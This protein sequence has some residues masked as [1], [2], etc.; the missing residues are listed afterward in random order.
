[1]VGF[2]HRVEL[3]QNLHEVLVKLERNLFA[4]FKHPGGVLAYLHEPHDDIVQIDVTQ[5]GVVFA[6]SSHL[7][8]EQIP[9]VHW[10]QQVLVFLELLMVLS[11]SCFGH[12]P[13]CQLLQVP[14]IFRLNFGFFSGRNLVGP[15]AAEL[16]SLSAAPGIF[17][18]LPA[19]LGFL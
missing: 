18:V 11:A 17:V 4:L 13:F 6:L 9:A 19:G 5:S 7:V 1:M 10:R 16:A 12:E 3:I 14:R 15:G 2:H 8:Q